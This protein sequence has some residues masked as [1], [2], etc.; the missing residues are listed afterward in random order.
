ML[1]AGEERREVSRGPEHRGKDARHKV[2]QGALGELESKAQPGLGQ[3][4]GPWAEMLHPQGT[5][6]QE[7]F[8]EE[9]TPIPSP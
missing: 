2:V 8:L 1:A 9:D 5:R 4:P 6:I 3:T 7:A